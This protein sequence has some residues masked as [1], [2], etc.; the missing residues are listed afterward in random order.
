MDPLYEYV[1]INSNS[2]LAVPSTADGLVLGQ[3]G[4]VLP[5]DVIM[6]SVFHVCICIYLYT[7][8]N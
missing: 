2:Y 3:T 7:V 1:L 8:T 4:H 6:C 5:T